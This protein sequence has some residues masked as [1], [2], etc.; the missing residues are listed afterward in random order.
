MIPCLEDNKICSNTNKKCKEC[1]FD[2]CK[3]V[4]NM[5]E[6]IQKYEDLD[7]LDKLNK[8]LPEQCKNCSFLEV[9]NL[10]KKIVYCPYMIKDKCLIEGDINGK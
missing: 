7:K 9:I 5:N 6:E 8:E 1:V 2:E 3:E 4:I 10:D